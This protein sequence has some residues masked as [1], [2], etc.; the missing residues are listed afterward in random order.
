M[1]VPVMPYTIVVLAPFLTRE[2]VVWTQD[3]ISIDAATIDQ[4]M[5]EFELTFTI[6][7]PKDIYPEGAFELHCKKFKDFHPDGLVKSDMFL[8]NI[9]DAKYF[10]IQAQHDGQ[11]V[12]AIHERLRQWP[13]LPRLSFDD[14]LQQPRSNNASVDNIF[15]M[16]AFPEGITSQGET[17]SLP[18]QIDSIL[19]QILNN[20]YSD[21]KFRKCE[22][23]WRGLRFLLEQGGINS[24]IKFLIVPTTK[25]SLEKTLD[26]LTKKLVLDPP[27]LI[28][29]DI[30][31]D[32]S[33][34]SVKLIEK[35][36]CFSET[37][38]APT[39]CWISSNFFHL[40]V[41]RD[42]KKLPHLPHYLEEAFFAKWRN[43]RQK[44]CARWLA[45]TCNC[46]LTRYQ[47]GAENPLRL[48]SF[49]ERD[50]LWI[51][52]VWAIASLMVQSMAGTGW[53]TCITDWRQYRL[54]DLALHKNADNTSVS[55]ETMIDDQRIA[56]LIHCGI[57]PLVGLPGR[58]R[59]FV[60][61]ETMA[62]NATLSYQAFVSRITQ[63][64]MWCR[65]SFKQELNPSK[66]Q[67]TIREALVLFAD[68]SG[69]QA[70]DDIDVRAGMS[71][72]DG[73]T[74]IR[75][76]IEPSRNILPGVQKLEMEFFW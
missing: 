72:G 12:E 31:F 73:R 66:L 41:W 7:V 16:V 26:N 10:I 70:F 18:D 8:K 62:G 58:D 29:V 53:A 69:L 49:E 55:T 13:D 45:L 56:Q 5:E 24:D 15:Q 17:G 28:L 14:T 9:F 65:E 38:L 52:P 71:A 30:P 6:P 44:D 61:Q 63:F 19:R 2:D 21:E 59:A 42:M 47:Y 23:L 46:F 64:L 37:L 43:L 48:V 40:D 76:S 3:P 51:S 27:S 25:D 54:E 33:A 74:V 75:I 36:A 1:Q 68:K 11:P 20:V 32:S 22:A 35:I 60:P 4:V 34:R 57:M 50:N 39:V 67:D